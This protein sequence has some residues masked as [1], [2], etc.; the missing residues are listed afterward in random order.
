[1][2]WY[3]KLPG[4]QTSVYSFILSAGQSSREITNWRFIGLLY[5]RKVIAYGTINYRCD[6][7]VQPYV[8]SLNKPCL[9]HFWTGAQDFAGHAACCTMH[10]W[11]WDIPVFDSSAST[12]INKYVASKQFRTKIRCTSVPSDAL[13]QYLK[14]VK[15]V[16][17]QTYETTPPKESAINLSQIWTGLSG[18]IMIAAC[19]YDYTT[20]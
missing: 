18:S 4:K 5:C 13:C 15:C 19:N 9:P 20:T 11:F 2:Q 14:E 17:T 3:K 8:N 16:S 12:N 1:M 6:G 10:W 7:L